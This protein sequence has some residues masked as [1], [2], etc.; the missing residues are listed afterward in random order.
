MSI[1]SAVP[2]DAAAIAAIYNYYVEH[3]TVS[4]ETVT[5]DLDTM[6]GRI[7]EVQSRGLPWLVA[8]CDQQLIGYAYATPWKPRQAYRFSVESSVYLAAQWC[9]RGL[10]KPLYSALIEALRVLPIHSALGGIALPNAASIALHEK[11]G[12]QKVGQLREIGF[13]QERW[14]DVGYWQLWF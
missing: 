9:G 4:F 8:E 1:R 14:I 2:A 11:L 3:T 13:K 6:Q 12:F 7:A 10:G 5:V